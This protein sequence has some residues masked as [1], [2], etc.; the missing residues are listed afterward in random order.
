[1][2]IFKN[3][4]GEIRSGWIILLC[5][6][7][8]YGLGYISSYVIIKILTGILTMTGDINYA[9]D[10]FSPLA[11]KIDNILPIALQI[12]TEVITITIPL[13]VWKVMKQK[14]EN[15]GL[16]DFYKI[17]KDGS[18]GLFLGFLG[19]T[20]IFIVLLWTKNAQIDKVNIRLDGMIIGWLFNFVM[21]GF[22]E[23]L[24]N[25]G[26]LMS[27]LRRTN[28][29][30]LIMA[31]PSIIFGLIHLMNPHITIVSLFNIIF[32]GFVFSYIYY[33]SGNLWMCI[34]YHITWNIFQSVIYGMPVSGL[35]VNHMITTHYPTNNLLNGG[36]FGIEGGILTTIISIFL[37]ILVIIYYK[38]SDYDFLAVMNKSQSPENSSTDA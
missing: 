9:T 7:L 13:V 21:V 12:L 11:N 3:Q 24:F 30:Y 26:F 15:L 33:K 37:L 28:N 17:K 36:F 2:K 31:V 5:F 16:R 29:K 23:E 27:V 32:I 10:Y 4:H 18:I 35:N 8:F 6:T 38:N 19:C 22:A 20:I 34:G 14:R 25:R 1:M